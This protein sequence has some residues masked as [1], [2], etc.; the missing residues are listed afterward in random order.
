MTDLELKERIYSK[1]ILKYYKENKMA[2]INLQNNTLASL[3]SSVNVPTL[4]RSE[5]SVGIVHLSVGNFMRSHLALYT[6]EMMT[7]TKD[8]TWGIAGM[9]LFDS[10]KDFDLSQALKEQDYLYTVLE[11][12]KDFS[13]ATICIALCALN[14]IRDGVT[15]TL[16]QLTDQRTKI[17]SMTITEGGYMSAAEMLENQQIQKDLKNPRNPKTLPGLIVEALRRRFDKGYP[18]FVILSCDN[19]IGNGQITKEM[20]TSFAELKNPALAKRIT[21]EVIFPNSMV[22]RITP[23]TTEDDIQKCINQYGI[24][25]LA[26]VPCEP[27]RQWV[28]EDSAQAV[29]PKWDLV[30]AQFVTDVTAFERIKLRLLNAGHSALGYSGHL[31]GYNYIDE[32]ANDPAFKKYLKKMLTEEVAPL[33]SSPNSMDLNEYISQ[34]IHR[35]SNPEIKDTALRICSDG[36]GKMPKFILPSIQSA[37][38]SKKS[39][40]ISRLSLVVA[41]WI[42]FLG[43]NAEVAAAQE[44]LSEDLIPLAQNTKQTGIVSGFLKFTP[45]FENLGESD[46]F[47]REVQQAYELLYKEGTRQT[48]ELYSK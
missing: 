36:S 26:P 46:I 42:K 45:V 15:R 32:V 4:D 20:I 41:S 30:G 43:D 8:Y 34:I 22:D 29:L 38:T 16:T 18:P 12:D 7:E 27:F 47:N 24:I 39:I 44:P 14:V 23:A 25:D 13:Q 1:E 3:S 11:K 21:D 33:L 2:A 19:V 37:L 10:K 9:N 6:Q 17:L 5:L 40:Q 28:I 31:A 35:F 48:I